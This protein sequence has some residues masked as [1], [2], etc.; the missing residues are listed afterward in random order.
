M[1]SIE[2]NPRLKDL[3][4]YTGDNWHVY[5]P[6]KDDRSFMEQ[7]GLTAADLEELCKDKSKNL[8]SMVL[9]AAGES[10]LG[11]IWLNNEEVN[12]VHK[13]RDNDRNECGD[14]RFCYKRP[15]PWTMEAK[16]ASANSKLKDGHIHTSLT[17]WHRDRKIVKFDNGSSL[18]TAAIIE[19]EY[20]VLAV[21]FW[22]IFKQH[23]FSFA[24]L[25]DL[26]RCTSNKVRATDYQK[27]K[28]MA[29]TVKV[30]WPPEHPFTDDL[31]ALLDSRLKEEAPTDESR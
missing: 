26:P 13:Q 7:V 14:W 27:S 1:K 23:V 2:S 21:S 10:S 20:D 6:T 24:F 31:F 17:I 15:E 28:M 22:H 4:R 8:W 30:S 19:G 16:T 29:S 25:N 3:H 11:R 18:Y 5:D 12:S 9:G